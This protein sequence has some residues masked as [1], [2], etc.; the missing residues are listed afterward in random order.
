MRPLVF[1]IRALVYSNVF[2]SICIT[3]LTHQT[4]IL[5]RLP[6]KNKF[7]LLIFVFCATFFIYNYQR[8]FR[9]KYRE[10]TGK[11][12]GIRFGWMVRNRKILLLGSILSAVVCLVLIFF[13]SKY[14]ILLTLPLALISIFHVVPFLS[15]KGKKIAIRNLPLVK[16]F[17]IAFVWAN[18]LVGLPYLNT[19]ETF[20]LTPEALILFISQFIFIM[21]I[22]LPFDIRDMAYDMTAKIKTLPHII[23]IKS[24]IMVSGFLLTIF[25]ALKFYQYKVHHITGLQFIALGTSTVITGIIIAFTNKKRSELFYSGLIEST[26]LII[27]FSVLILEY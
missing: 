13:M 4:Y 7:Y 5:L 17:L 15:I 25:L 26:M 21:A 22:T 20:K 6:E 14:F 24:T 9:L 18:V 3:L 10:L 23:G 8:L 12:I 16:I 11:Q 1:L 2:V 19:I 27:Y